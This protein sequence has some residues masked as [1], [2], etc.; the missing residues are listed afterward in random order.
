MVLGFVTAPI[1]VTVFRE[2]K[3]NAEQEQTRM[4]NGGS[5]QTTGSQ[6]S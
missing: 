6:K 5:T 4:L 2:K 1:S 3:S